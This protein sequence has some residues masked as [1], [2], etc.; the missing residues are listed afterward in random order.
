MIALLG[1]ALGDFPTIATTTT[2]SFATTRSSGVSIPVVVGI[3]V[4]V[5]IVAATLLLSMLKKRV[6]AQMAEIQKAREELRRT[7][8]NLNVMRIEK[9]EIEVSIL[10][11][12]AEVSDLKLQSAR[13][14]SENP[15][16]VGHQGQRRKVAQWATW[17][18][19]A[20]AGPS[21]VTS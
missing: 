1:R 5:C 7:E 9:E 10:A 11:L 16:P 4:A 14:K 18:T 8:N 12:R 15:T 17:I 19:N 6:D 2:A 3:I 21:R 13:I 20:I